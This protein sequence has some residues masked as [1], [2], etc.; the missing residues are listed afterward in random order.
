MRDSNFKPI[1]FRFKGAAARQAT[2]LIAE[3]LDLAGGSVDE[4][5]GARAEVIR[6]DLEVQRQTLHSLLRGEV[7]A[8]GVDANVHLERRSNREV[9]GLSIGVP[10]SLTHIV[11]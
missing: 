1:Q 3:D 5:V 2:Y 10:L 11:L 6:V 7:C 4:P 8:Q 9:E